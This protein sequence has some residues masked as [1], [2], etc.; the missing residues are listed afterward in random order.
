MQL[1]NEGF[2]VFLKDELTIQTD[3]FISNAIGG[4]K[5]QVESEN[6]EPSIELLK[7][8]GY[9]TEKHEKRVSFLDK[10]YNLTKRIPF[11]KSLIPEFRLLILVGVLLLLI[12]IPSFYTKPSLY[13]QLTQETWCLD[14]LNYKGNFYY[15]N[16]LQNFQL[17]IHGDCIEKIKFFGD[18]VIFPGF[19][20][21]PI[22]AKFSIENEE[23][24]IFESDTLGEIF[25]GN[26][27]VD[28][29]NGRLVMTSIKSSFISYQNNF[30]YKIPNFNY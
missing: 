15:P 13:V 30:H 3:N 14:T 10:V 22:N 4:V 17:I 1:E 28:I 18:D 24:I 23:L 7:S 8:L 27:S 11:L 20:T 25:D 29:N 2:N 5:I 12:L 21:H 16:T 6:V 19:E 26:Y 9:L